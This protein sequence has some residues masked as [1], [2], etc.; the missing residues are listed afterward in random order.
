MIR[1]IIASILSTAAFTILFN[2]R[3]KKII[4]AS[5]V[6][7]FAGIVLYTLID[8]NVNIAIAQFLASLTLS[9]L[10]EIFAKKYKTPVTTFIVCSLIPLVP[11]GGMYLAMKAMIESDIAK[12]NAILLDVLAQN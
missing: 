8:F 1:I 2:V 10:S 4:Y 5:I 3:G 11:G 6:G 12:G 9:S 7:M